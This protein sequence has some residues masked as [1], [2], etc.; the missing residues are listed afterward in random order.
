MFK[1]Q[2]KRTIGQIVKGIFSTTVPIEYEV[3]VADG[4]W[5]PYFGKYEN[6]RWG[7]WDSDSC[8]KLSQINCLEDQLE[9]LRAKGMFSAEALKF[10]ADNGYIDVDGDFSLSEQFGEILG[11]RGIQGG[12]AELAWQLDE[13]NGCIP[14][15]MLNYS[16]ARAAACPTSAAFVADYFNK[17]QITPAMTALGQQFLKYVR[18]RHQKIGVNWGTPQ[19]MVLTAALKQAPLQIGIPVPYSGGICLW[20]TP[21]IAYRGEVTADHEVELYKFVPGDSFPYKIFDQYM[22]NEKALAQNYYIPLVTQGVVDAIQ[23]VAVN[24]VI[25]PTSYWVQFWSSLFGWDN[26]NRNPTVPIGAA[27]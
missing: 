12:N 21:Y 20:N 13:D 8:W 1:L 27:K 17:A 6:Q 4:D 26:G 19:G 14:R 23:P 10:F 5:S 15:S 11:N 2:S 24:T 18:I 9:W 3:R 7:L 22:P 16:A 25:Q